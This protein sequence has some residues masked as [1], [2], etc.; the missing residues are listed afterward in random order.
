[1]DREH[2][3]LN[4]LVQLEVVRLTNGNGGWFWYFPCAWR[5]WI[6]GIRQPRVRFNPHDQIYIKEV[7]SGTV[8]LDH[9]LVLRGLRRWCVLAQRNLGWVRILFDY[10]RAHYVSRICKTCGEYIRWKEA[11]V[12]CALA[13]WHL[14]VMLAYI[15]EPAI[16]V[17]RE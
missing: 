2:S 4:A 14:P 3:I 8:H 6:N 12:E 17:G 9:D 10:P 5:I 13:H 15:Q 16:R 7:Q 11:D 1:M